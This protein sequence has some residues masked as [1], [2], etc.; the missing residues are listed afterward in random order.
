MKITPDADVHRLAHLMEADEMTA[1]IMLDML[2]SEYPGR[3]TSDIDADDWY[4]I[5]EEAFD[6]SRRLRGI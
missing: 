3:D 4:R 2:L 1:A 5:A 6:I